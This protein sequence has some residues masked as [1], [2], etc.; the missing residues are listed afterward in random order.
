M[1][2]DDQTPAEKPRGLL[3]GQLENSRG[4]LRDLGGLTVSTYQV[5]RGLLPCAARSHM[6]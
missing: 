2:D 6:R 5:T 4:L 1:I 3:R